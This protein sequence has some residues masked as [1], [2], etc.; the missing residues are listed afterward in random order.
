M[1]VSLASAA[2]SVSPTSASE[3]GTQPVDGPLEINERSLECKH[4]IA[5]TERDY[6]NE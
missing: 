1:K 4:T 5:A 2:L 6:R 3:I